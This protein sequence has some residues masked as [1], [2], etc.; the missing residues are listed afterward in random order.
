MSECCNAAASVPSSPTRH[1]CA[2]N[3]KEYRHVERKTLLHHLSEPW[4]KA[5][6]EQRYFFCSD[7]DCEVVYFGLDDSVIPKTDLRTAVGVK[8]TSPERTLCYCFGVTLEAARRDAHIRRFVEEQTRG[9]LCSCETSSPSGRCC[10]ANFPK[11]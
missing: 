9:S 8:E 5:I 3:G 11:Q 10:L 1:R 6:P 2:V 4:R 7:P